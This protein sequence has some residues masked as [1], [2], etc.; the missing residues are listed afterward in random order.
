MMDRFLIITLV[1]FIT[2]SFTTSNVDLTQLENDIVYLSID[3]NEDLIKM[4]PEKYFSTAGEGVIGYK[5]KLSVKG[6][7]TDL[8]V[9]K[10]SKLTFYVKM[11]PK[12]QKFSFS[13]FKFKTVKDKRVALSKEGITPDKDVE[14]KSA[15]YKAVELDSKKKLYRITVTSDLEPGQWGTCFKSISNG[16]FLMGYGY[17]KQSFC[18]EVE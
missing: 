11:D 3:G 4:K 18:F 1:L 17:G 8:K 15:V 6:A 14:I 16:K 5:S 10:G 2:V 7:T 13:I 12:H 9:K